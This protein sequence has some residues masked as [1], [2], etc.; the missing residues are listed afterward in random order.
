MIQLILLI[1]GLLLASCTGRLEDLKDYKDRLYA[2]EKSCGK[3]AAHLNKTKWSYEKENGDW[4]CLISKDGTE[5]FRSQIVFYKSEL[6][7]VL[8]FISIQEKLR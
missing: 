2:E 5:A 7:T 4:L 8:R 1:I 3:I 6:Y